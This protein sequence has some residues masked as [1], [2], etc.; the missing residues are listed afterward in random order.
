[1]TFSEFAGLLYPIIGGGDKTGVFV[2]ELFCS[3]V[4]FPPEMQDTNPLE[5]QEEPSFKSYFNGIRNIR[6]LAKKLNPYIDVVKFADKISSLDDGALV[7][8]AKAFE[9]SC[10]GITQFNVGDKLAELFQQI[11]LSAVESKKNPDNKEINGGVKDKF[12]TSLVIEANGVCPNDWCSNEL[13]T[14]V[15]GKTQLYYEVVKLDESGPDEYD[16]YIAV[17]PSCYKKIMMSRD[18]AVVSRLKEIKS[19]MLLNEKGK[20]TLSSEQLEHDIEAVL[21]KITITSSKELV[22]LNYEPVP[23]RSKIHEDNNLLYMKI[24]G[25]VA[26]YYIKVDEWLKQMDQEG[27]QK[28]QPFCN[29]MK[30]NYMKLNMQDLPQ[31]VIFDNL[32][33]WLQK[34]TNEN[35]TACEIVV[36]YFVQKCEVF[37]AVTE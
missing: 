7:N 20:V 26:A 16:N 28:F 22:P 11:M 32:S 23:V 27:R 13:E 18:P 2:R 14:D 15:D 17:C 36:A 6:L 10:P 30:I 9:K 24:R 37:D 4:E 34:N 19:K 21:E 25:Y 5:D 8:L 12:G 3:I 31:N 29:A 33:E 35:L 1:M